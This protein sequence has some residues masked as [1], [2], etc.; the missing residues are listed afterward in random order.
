M[1]AAYS[2]WFDPDLA[3]R[4]TSQPQPHKAEAIVCRFGGRDL[5]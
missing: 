2:R 5:P 4:E 3:N 1:A